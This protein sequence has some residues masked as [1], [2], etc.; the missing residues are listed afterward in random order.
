MFRRRSAGHVG[1]R[2][3]DLSARMSAWLCQTTFQ[4]RQ[5]VGFVP[6]SL[7]RLVK[8]VLGI[9]AED[10]ADAGD[11]RAEIRPVDGTHPAFILLDLE[12]Q[13]QYGAHPI[14]DLVDRVLLTTAEVHHLA[15][16]RLR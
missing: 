14:D 5:E 6:H 8:Y 13:T 10:L 3:G 16:A 2:K 9:P 1:H 7:Q 11:V 4:F 15:L 12:V